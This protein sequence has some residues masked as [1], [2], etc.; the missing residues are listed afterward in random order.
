MNR[1]SPCFLKSRSL[2]YSDERLRRRFARRP[3][4]RLAIYCVVLEIALGMTIGVAQ[5]TTSQY[6]NMRTQKTQE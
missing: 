4:E 5:V 2:G 1:G 6:D 3:N